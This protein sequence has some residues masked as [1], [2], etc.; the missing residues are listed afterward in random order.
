MIVKSWGFIRKSHFYHGGVCHIKKADTL[1]VRIVK[2]EMPIKLDRKATLSKGFYSR[3]I[4]LK[5]SQTKERLITY[6]N[7]LD[8]SDKN[9]E[10]QL[11]LIFS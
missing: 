3:L 5:L 7:N 1:S 11:N 10:A 2:K 6:D 4:R 8:D 9:K